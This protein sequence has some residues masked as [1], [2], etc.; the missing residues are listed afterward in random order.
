[1]GDGWMEGGMDR[2]INGQIDRQTSSALN[3]EQNL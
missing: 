1:M 3:L 2:W